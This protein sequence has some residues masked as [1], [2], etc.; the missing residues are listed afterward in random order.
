MTKKNAIHEQLEGVED[1]SCQ[2]LKERWKWISWS[3]FSKSWSDW[4]NSQ[5]ICTFVSLWIPLYR[6][7]E[8]AAIVSMLTPNTIFV[9]SSFC[10]S[11]SWKAVQPTQSINIL[12]GIYRNELHSNAPAMGGDGD[13]HADQHHRLPHQHLLLLRRP[14]RRQVLR[15]G[16]DRVRSPHPRQPPHTPAFYACC[17]FCSRTIR[18]KGKFELC[19]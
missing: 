9:H 10:C 6:D 8:K 18:A 14:L 3:I 17:R 11:D 19:I 7:R 5:K 16:R 13:H 2:V 12:I 4:F 15:R 1:V